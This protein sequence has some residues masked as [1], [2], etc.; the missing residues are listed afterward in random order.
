MKNGLYPLGKISKTHGYSGVLFLVSDNYLDDD[1]EA[2]LNEIFLL[3]DGLYVPFPIIEFTLRTDTSA[4]IRLEFVNNQTDASKLIGSEV[5]TTLKC[6]G[7][8]CPRPGA[9]PRNEFELW[10]GFTVHETKH[11]KV[12]VIQKIEDYKGNIVIH[13]IDG[14]K[15][16]LISFFP[17]LVT[18]TD[19]NEKILY[20]NAPDGY[21]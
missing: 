10:I 4:L 18:L 8:A 15:E 3:I 16:T 9:F 13:I 19:D 2:G 14:D 6:T 20:I 12:G 5:F 7:G 11:G 1:L 17:E 21:F